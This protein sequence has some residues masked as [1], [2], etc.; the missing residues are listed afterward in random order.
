MKKFDWGDFALNKIRRRKKKHFSMTCQKEAYP[1][2]MRKIVEES[3]PLIQNNIEL[4]FRL[5][6]AAREMLANALEHGCSCE[7]EKIEIVLT[8]GDSRQIKLRVISP[9]EGFDV[10]EAALNYMP[11]LETRGRGLP[12]I[13]IAADRVDFNEKGNIITAVFKV[14]DNMEG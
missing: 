10:G 3:R 11:K 1:E 8:L 6:M 2:V 4:K 14:K 5:E 9:G 13:K 12:I 7:E